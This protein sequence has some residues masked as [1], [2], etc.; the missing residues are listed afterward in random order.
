[1]AQ[2]F[3]YFIC[4]SQLI[5]SYLN[6][7]VLIHGNIFAV[8]IRVTS[9]Q[10]LNCTY[11]S[12]FRHITC[13]G[14]SENGNTPNCNFNDVL[15]PPNSGVCNLLFRATQISSIFICQAHYIRV[16]SHHHC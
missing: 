6:L 15:E 5:S 4:L 2:V 7:S 12:L 10:E 3:L 11:Y 16:L 13:M 14:L 8:P 9:Y 1:M